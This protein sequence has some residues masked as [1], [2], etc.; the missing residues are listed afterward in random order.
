MKQNKKGFTLVELIVVMAIIAVLAAIL[1][2]TMLGFMNNAK[3]TQANANAKT[4]HTAFS[5]V[6]SDYCTDNPVLTPNGAAKVKASSGATGAGADE[7]ENKGNET[8]CTLNAVKFPGMTK[9]HSGFNM[10]QYLDGMKG[11]AYVKVNASGT[12]VAFVSWSLG[13][14]GTA[15]K[16]K[17]D[18][19]AAVGSANSAY[20][21]LGNPI[22]CF[23][24][25]ENTT[26]TEP[27]A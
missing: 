13:D 26:K 11:N 1:V 7:S 21:E 3:F 18:Q 17:D 25:T 10:T 20:D 19:K 12:G 4:I 22:G 2:P 6:I 24:L 5:S 8:D 14:P 23:P 9:D 16:S 27:E 15:Q